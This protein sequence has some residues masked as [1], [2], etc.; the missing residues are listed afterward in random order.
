M[1][2]YV[3]SVGVVTSS[4]VTKME[5]TPFDPN[6]VKAPA[7]C[8]LHDCVFYRTGVIADRSIT[9]TVITSATHVVNL[10]TT[11]GASSMAVLR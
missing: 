10:S 3:E 2:F 11:S 1:S 5:V 6:G 8:R 4:Q 9:L 7:M